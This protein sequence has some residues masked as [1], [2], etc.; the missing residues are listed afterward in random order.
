[1]KNTHPTHSNTEKKYV[2]IKCE[3]KRGKRNLSNKEE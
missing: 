3:E 1:M 2:K